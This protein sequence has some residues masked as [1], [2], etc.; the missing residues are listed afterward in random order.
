MPRSDQA[1]SHIAVQYGGKPGDERTHEEDYHGPES[2]LKAK[3]VPANF[4]QGGGHIGNS[5]NRN[6]PK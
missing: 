1:I 4:Y 5:G 2:R 6:P 3:P